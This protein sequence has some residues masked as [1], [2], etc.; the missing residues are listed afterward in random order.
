[1]IA[2]NETEKKWV[3]EMW[4]RLDKK[5]SKTCISARGKLP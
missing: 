3:G 2:L 5:L 1:M 4:E